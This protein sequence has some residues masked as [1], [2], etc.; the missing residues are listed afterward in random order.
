MEKLNKIYL[1]LLLI[2]LFSSFS[3]NYGFKG[4]NPPEGVRTIYIF[5][6]DDR[7]GFGQQNLSENFTLRLKDKFIRDN[8]LETADRTQADASLNCAILSVTDDPLI[9]TGGEQVS[10]RKI[11]IRVSVDFQNLDKKRQIWNKEFT[12]YGEYESSG[13]GFSKRDE[14]ILIAVDRITDDILLE[15]TS[16]W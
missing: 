14:G 10:R 12:N 4:S 6:F 13:G 9:I 11:T 2:F 1:Y 5:P 16:N 8:T 15:V 7:S 3:C